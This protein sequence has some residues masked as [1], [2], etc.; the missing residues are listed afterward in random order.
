MQVINR[1]NTRYMK[2]IYLPVLTILFFTTTAMKCYKDT[3]DCH[4]GI[5]LLNTS[6]TAVYY[7]KSM[8]SS[9]DGT[10]D[11]KLQQQGDESKCFSNNVHNISTSYCYE[12][13]IISSK[14]EAFYFYFFDVSV[15]DNTPW[16]SIVT[17]KQY[18]KKVKYT[19]NDFQQSGRMVYYP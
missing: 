1:I 8:D 11:P 13:E 4:H 2:R 6:P 9:L 15:I 18:L 16:D 5:G 17:R 10:L 14:H 3:P 12:K 19:L 7:L